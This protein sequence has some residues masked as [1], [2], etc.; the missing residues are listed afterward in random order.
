MLPWAAVNYEKRMPSQSGADE[1]R[2]ETR[3]KVL[4][5]Y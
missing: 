1:T 4:K 3:P 2:P 5:A